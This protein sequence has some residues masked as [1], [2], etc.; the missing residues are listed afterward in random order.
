M[1]IKG[2]AWGVGEEGQGSGGVRRACALKSQ[3]Q[4]HTGDKFCKNLAPAS[5]FFKSSR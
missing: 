2:R 4:D 5:V 3:C 1:I